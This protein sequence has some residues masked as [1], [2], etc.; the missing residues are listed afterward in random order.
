MQIDLMPYQVL[1]YMLL[2]IYV[3]WGT[4]DYFHFSFRTTIFH[5]LEE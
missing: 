2:I 5:P 3:P 1:D 4:I